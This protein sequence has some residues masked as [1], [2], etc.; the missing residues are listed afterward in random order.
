MKSSLGVVLAAIIV[1][2]LS[3]AAQARADDGVTPAF[4]VGGVYYENSDGDRRHDESLDGA[5]PLHH[6]VLTVEGVSHWGNGPLGSAA[7]Q[8]LLFGFN[9]GHSFPGSP[10]GRVGFVRFD[11][12]AKPAGMLEVQEKGDAGELRLRAEYT[13]LFET[14]EMIRNE[15]MFAGIELRGKALLS[16]RLSP[17]VQLFLRDYS[18]NNDSVRAR[19]DLPCAVILSP[20]HWE[21]GYRQEYA[22]FRRQTRGGY[23]DPDELNSFQ[24]VSSISY[25]KEQLQA[26]AEIFGGLQKSRT[27]GNSSTDGFVGVYAEAVLKTSGSFQFGLTAE[28]DDYSLGSASGFRHVQIG[29][30]LTKYI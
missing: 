9:G 5:I 4:G 27:S 7:S 8:E 24:A 16:R 23:F 12:G 26:Y 11:A 2:L 13:P 1:E 21:L 6:L 19:G 17:A 3:Q 30:R 15:I 14:A 10:K 25:W 20:V 22:A 28:G 18:D 29:V